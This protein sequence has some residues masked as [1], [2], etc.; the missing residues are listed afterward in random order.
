MARRSNK[1]TNKSI[2]E[3][4]FKAAIIVSKSGGNTNISI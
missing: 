4:E 3:M 1:Q 2:D